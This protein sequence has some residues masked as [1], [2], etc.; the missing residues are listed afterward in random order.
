MLR[1]F[2]ALVVL[3]F[4]LAPLAAIAQPTP[5]PLDYR[6]YDGWNAIRSVVLAEDG[7]AIAYSLVPEDGDATLVVRTIASGRETREPR[8]LAPQFTADGK[9]LVYTIAPLKT[10]LDAAKKAKKKPEDSPKNGLGVL[11]LTSG[12]LVQFERIKDAKIAKHGG[13]FIA[14][15]AEPKKPLASKS[16]APSAAPSNAPNPAASAE[17]NPAASASASPA[18]SPS[19]TPDA[20]KKD[21][22]TELT[23]RD[24]QT[25]TNVSVA[26]VSDYAISADDRSVAYATQSKDGKADGMHVRALDGGAARDLAVGP[27]HFTNVTFSPEGAQLAY[28][29][30]AST[31]ASDAP[32]YALF[33]LDA[34]AAATPVKLVDAATDG[35]PAT[36]APSTNGTLAFTKD[37]KKLFLGTAAVPTPQPMNTPEPMGV[38]L[39]SYRDSQLQSVQK[40]DADIIA[41]RTL[42]G[43]VDL[44]TGR[45][46][47]LA[48]SQMRTVIASDE[49]G[50]Y[51]LGI[52]SRAYDTAASWAPNR[53]DDYLV[54][55]ADGSRRLAF[56]G[57]A[58][59]DQLSPASTYL[60]AYDEKKRVWGIVR[61]RDGHR[62]TIA[63]PSGAHWYDELDDHPAPPPAYGIGGWLAGDRGV[64]LY[65]RY[66][67][68][69]ADP[70][71][72]ALKNLTGGIGRKNK[73]VFR[74]VQPDKK[75]T[76]FA[77]GPI[78][79]RAFD[80]R[81][82]DSGLYTA[83]IG[84]TSA[85]KRIVMQARAVGDPIKAAAA[86]AYAF[87]WQSFVDSPNLYVSDANF[88][89][90]KKISDANPQQANYRWGTAHLIHYKNALG[91]PM[92]GVVLVPDGYD[93][94]KTYPML[95]YFYERY[96][97]TLNAYHPPAPGTSP[98]FMRYVSNGYVVLLP[99]VAYE[100]GHPGR[101]ALHCILPA[102]DAAEKA[103]AIDDKRVGIAGH[104]WAAYQINYMITKTHRF[105][106]VE[107]GAAVANMTSA[108]G[109]I[110]LESGV[111]REGQYEY[112]QSR[113]GA[114][115]WDR[116]D[117]YLENSGLFHIK[118]VTTPYLTIHNDAD[119]AV[120]W[121]QGVEYFT[122]MRRLHKE[123]Y[124]FTF[125]GEVHNLR[126]REAQKYWTVHM[127]EWFDHYLKGAPAPAWM[128]DGVAYPDHG[129]RNVR[130]LFGEQER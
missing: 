101:S 45:Y 79:L 71:S 98:N 59:D 26:N 118:D 57:V 72:G 4:L 126:G 43:V 50:A 2:S 66:D 51:A 14:F 24:L 42:R 63:A 120:P 62:T 65:D 112:G 5:P 40:H 39:W 30:D 37:G 7:S 108:Y 92:N 61:A 95:V 106:A 88:A 73:I 3:C 52:D 27:G 23:I 67:I 69:L 13:R 96:S 55:L 130:A 122:A 11:D 81:S 38:D 21:D 19:P 83:D 85:P 48:S 124:M 121:S 75:R 74:A 129:K 104:S 100:V 102:I 110:R 20:K 36:L 31:Y 68:W 34:A 97:D 64:L 56:R 99:D 60:V 16:D 22:G 116:P 94:R 25:G 91:T 113:I 32:H 103:Y 46:V 49:P 93:K 70:D 1:R 117:L 80:E 127:D 107:A 17:P 86:D 82:K 15:L 41:K 10:D 89:G 78:V 47:Q 105:R 6:A 111:V 119:D 125:N 115:P 54:S 128:T 84:A 33:A 28:L 58:E 9:F 87:T 123:A 77:P 18:P 29:S 8:G 90:A 76:S 35:L 44:A 53:R 12:T 109:G 114:T